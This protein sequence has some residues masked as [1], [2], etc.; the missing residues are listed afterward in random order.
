MR[1]DFPATPWRDDLA[2]LDDQLQR[3]GGN[4]E[5]QPLNR[6]GGTELGVFSLKPIGLVI[7]KVLLDSQ[8]QAILLEGL[9]AG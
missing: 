2:A 5:K 8:A 9:Q 4:T 6:R 7:Q 3:G 1:I